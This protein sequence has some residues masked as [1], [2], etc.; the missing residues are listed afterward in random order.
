MSSAAQ[1][2]MASLRRRLQGCIRSTCGYPAAFVLA[3]GIM[4]RG[5][6]GVALVAQV[7]ARAGSERSRER[8]PL[9]QTAR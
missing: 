9:I 1:R 6:T 8:V 2:E 3:G 7:R 5:A 4:V